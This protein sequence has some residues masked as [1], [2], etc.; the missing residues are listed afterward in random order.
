MATESLKLYLVR[1]FTAKPDDKHPQHR[2]NRADRAP[3]APKWR[4]QEQVES[5][6]D[7]CAH[8]V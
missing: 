4:D 6:A 2:S 3:T 5:N 8:E 7:G 1:R